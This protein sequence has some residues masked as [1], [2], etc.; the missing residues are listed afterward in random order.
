VSRI[1]AKRLELAPEQ[2]DLA[3]LV[4]DVVARYNEPLHRAG[5][6]LTLHA[7]EP[8]TGYWDRSRMEQVVVNLLSNAMKYGR[9]TP[10]NV[11]VWATETEACFCV[12]DRGI[13][14][15]TEDRERIFGRFERA[16]S[17][18]TFGGLGLGLY[19]VRQILEESGGRISIQSEPG[20]GSTFTVV[21]PRDTRR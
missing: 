3:A 8:A 7:D 18:K 12:R 14:I 11:A 1:A 2:M 15:S 17:S 6:T 9:G 10:I 19:I 21:V 13:G 4:R 20:R 16:V 5:C